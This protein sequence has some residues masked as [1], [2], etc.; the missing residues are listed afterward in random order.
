MPTILIRRSL[1]ALAAFAALAIATSATAV[2]CNPAIA[3]ELRLEPVESASPVVIVRID[4]SPRRFIVEPGA[5]WSAISEPAAAA[6]GLRPLPLQAREP[7]GTDGGVALSQ[8]AVAERFELGSL[9]AART[10]LLLLPEQVTGRDVDG[11]LGADVLDRYDLDFDFAAHVLRLVSPQHCPG[12][13]VRWTREYAAAPFRIAPSRHLVVEMMLDGKQVSVAIDTARSRT[14]LSASSAE[15]L[16]GLTA[17]SPDVDVPADRAAA[18]A[19]RFRK[20]FESLALGGLVIR[21]PLVYVWA[22]GDAQAVAA[23]S[24]ASLPVEGALG[25]P[26]ERQDLAIGMDVLRHLHLYVAFAEK[27]LYLSTADAH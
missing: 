15:R 18:G 23:R 6:T 22:D 26:L 11:V 19:L 1:A 3:A 14:A 25:L 9:P 16:Y 24:A 7:T 21:R 13:V 4:G 27:M 20:Q 5:L 17:A 12:P 2:D 8:F 10:Q